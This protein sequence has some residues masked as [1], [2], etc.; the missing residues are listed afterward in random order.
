MTLAK[1]FVI[2]GTSGSTEPY[3]QD[4]SA[5]RFWKVEASSPPARMSEEEAATLRAFL[6]STKGT[7]LV[8]GDLGRSAGSDDNTDLRA[9]P[10]EIY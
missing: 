8:E 1:P 4:T 5:R 10:E 9:E 2:I 7:W 3:L 6:D